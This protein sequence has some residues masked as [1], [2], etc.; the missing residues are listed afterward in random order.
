MTTTKKTFG[1]ITQ[2]KN[3]IK[4]KIDDIKHLTENDN[5]CLIGSGRCAKH[6]TRVNRVIENRR[7]STVNKDG[8]V[9]WKMCEVTILSCP[10]VQAGAS[11]VS[12][13]LSVQ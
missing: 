9:S 8:S 12:S 7:V 11:T 6:N 1:N 13:D 5:K 2:K 10:A 4:K 3:S